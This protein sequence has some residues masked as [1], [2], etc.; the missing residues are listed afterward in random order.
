MVPADSLPP[1][2]NFNVP[3]TTLM[4]A[5]DVC[6]GI[7]IVEMPDPDEECRVPKLS[8]SPVTSLVLY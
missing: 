7:E 6:T 4:L 5:N 8:K 3:V 2:A 1:P